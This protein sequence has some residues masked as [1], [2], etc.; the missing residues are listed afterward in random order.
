[1]QAAKF[2]KKPSKNDKDKGTMP[3]V[4]YPY[5]PSVSLEHLYRP[6]QN[7]SYKAASVDLGLGV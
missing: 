5:P 4:R 3:P 7:V 2:I 1:M 6:P